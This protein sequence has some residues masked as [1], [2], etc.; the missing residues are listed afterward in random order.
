MNAEGISV[1]Y[2]ALD[3]KT[4]VAEL[5]PSLGSTVVSGAFQL[6]NSIR[7]LDFQLL[8]KCY[9][10]Q[11]LSYFQPDFNEKV[12]YRHLLRRLHAK[13]RQ[14][15]LPG[16]EHEYLTTQALSEYLVNV[17]QPPID[18]ILFSSVQNQSGLNVVLFGHVLD[19]QSNPDRTSVMGTNSVLR[20][21][22]NSTYIHRVKMI[23]Y[24]FDER[25]ANDIKVDAPYNPD[26]DPDDF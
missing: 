8:E 13:I 10:E 24:D 20:H 23:N 1:F 2:G 4:C 26:E 11:P 12:T 9:H 17:I 22:D 16:S 6:C 21:F 19:I 3:R 7:V 15:I 25:R 5:R 18:G 14:P